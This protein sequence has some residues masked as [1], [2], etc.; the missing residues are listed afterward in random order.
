MSAPVKRGR[1]PGPPMKCAWGCDGQFTGRQLPAHLT[2]CP[3]RPAAS[4]D[5]ERRRGTLKVKRGRP[6][7]PR[8]KCGWGC[9]T[10]PT[11]CQ[12]RAHLTICPKRPAGSDDV[13]R[14]GGSL[15][16]SVGA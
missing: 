14:R 12:M 8:M 16:L 9:G 13:D 2:V 4:A 3:K 15:R 6:A 7:G 10:D 11:R 1:P 5:V